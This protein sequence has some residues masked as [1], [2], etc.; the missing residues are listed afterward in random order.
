MKVVAFLGF[1]LG[2]GA[3]DKHREQIRVH[4]I[5]PNSDATFHRNLQTSWQQALADELLVDSPGGSSRSLASATEWQ[6]ADERFGNYSDQRNQQRLVLATFYFATG[7]ILWTN[8]T[9][10]LSYAIDE[11]EWYSRSPLDQV[12]NDDGFYLHLNLD[13]NNLDGTLPTEM[14]LLSNLTLLNLSNNSLS[15]TIPSSLQNLT[16]LTYIN[17]AYNALNGSIPATLLTQLTA[18]EQL[19]LDSNLLTGT[20]PSGISNLQR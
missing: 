18:L 15:N 12:C 9:G 13:N 4:E 3:R 2:V 16:S 6:Q 20:I 19:G 1:L 5:P 11:C 8:N 10:W 17:L 14:F 7:G